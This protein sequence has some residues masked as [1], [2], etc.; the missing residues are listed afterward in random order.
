[1]G[2]LG[3]DDSPPLRILDFADFSPADPT[4]EKRFCERLVE[5]L[6]SVGFVK[7]VNHGITDEEVGRVF[8]WVSFKFLICH[9]LNPAT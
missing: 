3:H 8:E 9:M 6:S 1:M 2:S 7:L 4:T 5:A